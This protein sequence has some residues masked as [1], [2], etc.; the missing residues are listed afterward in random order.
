MA[1]QLHQ[2]STPK[3]LETFT[4]EVPGEPPCVC[5][6]MFE[7]SLYKIPDSYATIW[8]AANAIGK[9]C[10]EWLQELMRESSK[11]SIQQD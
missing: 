9:Q 2:S 3:G 6:F 5:L 10:P 11:S 7:G 4:I 8:M 1:S